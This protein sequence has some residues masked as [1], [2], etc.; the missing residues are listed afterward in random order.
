MFCVSVVLWRRMIQLLSSTTTPIV[1]FLSM[2][3]VDQS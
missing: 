1:Q 3:K 2:S